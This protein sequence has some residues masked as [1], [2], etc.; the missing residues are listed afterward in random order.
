MK[1]K[2]PSPLIP[3]PNAFLKIGAGILLLGWGLWYLTRSVTAADVGQALRLTKIQFVLAAQGLVLL[4][5]A[6]KSR[7]WQLLF[8]P[9]EPNHTFAAS[10]WAVMLGQFVN[11]AVSFM[12]L[13]EI[14]RV[15][16]LRQQTG[17]SQMRALGTL[18]L[19]KNLDIIMLLLTLAAALPFAIVPES[20]TER[21]ALMGITAVT[22]L[23]LLFIIAYQSRR[24][25]RLIQTAADRYNTPLIDRLARWTRLGLDGLAALRSRRAVLEA[26][27]ASLLIALLSIVTSLTLFP[28]FNL[29]FG[30]AEAALLHAGTSLAG[31]LPISTP[32]KIGLFETAVIFMLTHFGLDNEAVALSYA[33]IFHLIIL[34]PQLIFGAVAASRTRW[35]WQPAAAQSTAS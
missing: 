21:G 9:R 2:K 26:L 32:G 19:E 1:K 12:R 11:S 14:A 20:I 25:I 16:A 8:Y 4:T 22:A 24:I 17:I 13:G 15:Y 5:L 33:L 35:R 29:P 23:L 6:A 28:A 7:R 27:S 10:F 30:L 31:I 3:A 34:L 18:V